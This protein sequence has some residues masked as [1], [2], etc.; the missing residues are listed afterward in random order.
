MLIISDTIAALIGKR[1][2]KPRFFGKS[3]EG[4]FAFFLSGVIVVALTPKVAYLPMEYLIGAVAVM[5]GTIVEAV[6]VGTDDNLAI[7]LATGG[8]LWLMYAMF[9]PQLNVATNF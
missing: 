2:G 1:F 3:I 4:S 6:P 5:V 7:P 9:L 8:T